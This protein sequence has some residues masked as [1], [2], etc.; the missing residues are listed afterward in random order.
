MS[1]DHLSLRVKTMLD[2]R[3]RGRVSDRKVDG[4]ERWGGWREREKHRGKYNIN[5]HQNSMSMETHTHTYKMLK[6]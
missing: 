3:A 5:M 4:E 2:N 6:E 1:R